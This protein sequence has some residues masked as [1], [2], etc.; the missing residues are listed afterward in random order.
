MMQEE[1]PVMLCESTPAFQQFLY[2]DLENPLKVVFPVRC[3]TM[4]QPPRQTPCS[5]H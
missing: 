2:K 4:V 5:V 1:V 3:E